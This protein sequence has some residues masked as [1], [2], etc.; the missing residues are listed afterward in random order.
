MVQEEAKMEAKKPS[1][2]AQGQTFEEADT[3]S[4]EERRCKRRKTQR[5]H[6]NGRRFYD[7]EDPEAQPKESL[8]DLNANTNA[9]NIDYIIDGHTARKALLQAAFGDDV[10]ARLERGRGTRQRGS[11]HGELPKHRLQPRRFQQRQTP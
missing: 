4:S 2:F 7:P 11:D 3:D 6:P 9:N 8:E 10:S 1:R 5:R